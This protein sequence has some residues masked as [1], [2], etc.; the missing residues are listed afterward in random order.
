MGC[1]SPQTAKAGALTLSLREFSFE[2]YK[3]YDNRDG[4]Y[5]YSNDS[6]ESW[7]KGT[8][9]NFNLD[10]V[11]FSDNVALRWDNRVHGETTVD[12]YRAVGWQFQLAVDLGPKFTLFAD[13]HS[14]HILDDHVDERFP[15]R[16][17]VGGRVVFYKRDK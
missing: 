4:Y 9:V 11:R 2:T 3:L 13:H 14:Q 16:N 17:V 10:L 5:P 7:D 8:A 6:N 1:L 15:L 12:Q